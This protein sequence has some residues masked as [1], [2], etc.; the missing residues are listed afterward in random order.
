MKDQRYMET[1]DNE[2]PA[3][4]HSGG[5]ANMVLRGKFIALQSYHKKQE[6]IL[7]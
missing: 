7:K 3:Y 6:K 5:A 4:Q 1:N 2:N